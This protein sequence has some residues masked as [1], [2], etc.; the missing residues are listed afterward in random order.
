M[1][2]PLS[3]LDRRPGE[4]DPE[5]VRGGGQPAA[6]NCRASEAAVSRAGEQLGWLVRRSC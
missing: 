4:G 3:D 5:F 2:E 1:F 6:Q